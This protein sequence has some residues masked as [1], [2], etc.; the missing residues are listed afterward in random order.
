M[1][2]W[3]FATLEISSGGFEYSGSGGYVPH[4]AQT[5]GS[6]SQQFPVT[7]GQTYILTFQTY[8]EYCNG[9][10][11]I[12]VTFGDNQSGYTVTDC[13]FSV[14]TFHNNTFSYVAS[15][16]T[17]NLMFAFIDTTYYTGGSTN[18][19]IANGMYISNV[20][21]TSLQDSTW[22]RQRPCDFIRVDSIPRAPVS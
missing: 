18:M 10:S 20:L 7:A 3:Q 8:F 22:L 12:D 15:G 9:Q 5:P 17:A 21:G 6:V 1:N 14:G 11:E 2:Q 19:V 16:S 13:Q 4:G